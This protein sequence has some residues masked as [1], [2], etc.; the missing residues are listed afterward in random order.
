MSIT[1]ETLDRKMDAILHRL[2]AEAPRGQFLSVKEV[3]VLWGVTTDTVRRLVATGQLPAS[4]IGVG[5]GT[6]RF[7]PA[8][9]RRHQLETTGFT[10]P[11]GR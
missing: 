5:R 2:G 11:R 8:D 3:A 6:L 10:L 4:R 9:L 1:L 7:D